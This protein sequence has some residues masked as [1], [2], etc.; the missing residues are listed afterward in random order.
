MIVENDMSTLAS[1]RFLKEKGFHHLRCWIGQQI[2]RSF[3]MPDFRIA[4]R[5]SFRLGCGALVFG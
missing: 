4:G 2:S 5:Y 1:G 3:M